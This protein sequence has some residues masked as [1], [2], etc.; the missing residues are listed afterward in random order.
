MDATRM[1]MT[2]MREAAGPANRRDM[3]PGAVVAVL[4]PVSS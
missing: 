2:V 4:T 1:P 3:R